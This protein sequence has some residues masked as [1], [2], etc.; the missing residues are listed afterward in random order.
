M[1]AVPPYS[2]HEQHA[3][4]SQAQDG[5]AGRCRQK[6]MKLALDRGRLPRSS[7]RWCIAGFPMAVGCHSSSI[8]GFGDVAA[9]TILA[10]FRMGEADQPGT[11]PAAGRQA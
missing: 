11:P 8:A 4:K 2:K 5:H 10:I 7:I 6:G 9:D 3:E 1:L